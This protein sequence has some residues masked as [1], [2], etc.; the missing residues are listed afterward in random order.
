MFSLLY[1]TS[2]SM[3][4]HLNC[5]AGCVHILPLYCAYERRV[6]IYWLS[7]TA[8]LLPDGNIQTAACTVASSSLCVVTFVCVPARNH[9]HYV[10][11]TDN[12]VLGSAAKP[13]RWFIRLGMH[14]FLLV[15]KMNTL[16]GSQLWHCC[17]HLSVCTVSFSSSSSFLFRNNLYAAGENK[18][19]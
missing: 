19:S 5:G 11:R 15:Y 8:F 13:W 12:R 16:W 6:C 7:R 2:P 18:T 3:L 17:L 14:A 9:F 10:L 4:W 1:F